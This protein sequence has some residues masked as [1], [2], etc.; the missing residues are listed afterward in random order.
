M[1]RE[2]SIN[3]SSTPSGR[4]NCLWKD[5]QG[6]E[7]VLYFDKNA[8]YL[9]F[10]Q[11]NRH[12]VALQKSMSAAANDF[13]GDPDAF[14]SQAA[15]Q[16]HELTRFAAA[17]PSPDT[18]AWPTYQ[19]FSEWIPPENKRKRGWWLDSDRVAHYLEWDPSKEY[20][21][22]DLRTQSWYILNI[23]I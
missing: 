2:L 16:P 10:N 22:Q 21:H 19:L 6:Q 17:I 1:Q 23:E 15:V 5:D 7:H 3:C 12:W 14:V 4:I 11:V 13:P 9:H 18:S 20:A 8:E